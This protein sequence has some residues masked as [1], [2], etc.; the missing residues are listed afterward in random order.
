MNSTKN[1]PGPKDRRPL[2]LLL[3]ALCILGLAGAR[4]SGLFNLSRQ[5]IA[6]QKLAWRDD[7]VPPGLYLVPADLAPEPAGT[8]AAQLPARLAPLFFQ[9]IS[10]NQADEELL[11]TISGIGPVFARRI[12]EF[13]DQQGRINDIE[14][15]DAVKG[16][17]PAK[18]K[19]LKA[20]LVPD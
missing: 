16:V 19:I 18:L 11:T 10:L 12:I 7:S 1:E 13:R 15:L 17:G 3:F 9:P 2:A 5:T 20:H 14:E 6:P 8:V 4:Q